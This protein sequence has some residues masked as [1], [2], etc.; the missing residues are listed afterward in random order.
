MR[1][2][3]DWVTTITCRR[4]R[5][6]RTS[7]SSRRTS[8]ATCPPLCSYPQ[9]KKTT[10]RMWKMLERF[11]LLFISSFHFFSSSQKRERPL[12]YVCFALL[13][14]F[15]TTIQNTHQSNTTSFTQHFKHFLVHDMIDAGEHLQGPQWALQGVA[16]WRTKETSKGIRKKSQPGQGAEREERR[17][18]LKIIFKT[19]RM[20]ILS[21]FSRLTSFADF[22]KQFP[23]YFSKTTNQKQFEKTNTQKKLKIYPDIKTINWRTLT[24]CISQSFP[25][26]QISKKVQKQPH[27]I[28]LITTQWETTTLENIASKEQEQT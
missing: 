25:F 17:K 14:P 3:C 24:D 2:C 20:F 4:S 18:E 15:T 16:L 22:R 10:K 13:S 27:N 12:P 6:G 19:T 21:C 11:F 5:S 26:L 28:F 8:Q 1:N 9:A 7:R 23:V